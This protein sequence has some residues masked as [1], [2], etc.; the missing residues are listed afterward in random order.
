MWKDII[1]TSLNGLGAAARGE[2]C[3]LYG[4]NTITPHRVDQCVFVN[5]RFC[6]SIQSAG[7]FERLTGASH[8]GSFAHNDAK[9]DGDDTVATNF[10]GNGVVVC[11]GGSIG[12]F[13]AGG[14][15]FT[16]V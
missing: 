5:A 9:V 4:N 1:P 8:N 15:E 10:I 16:T 6:V 7:A 13:S 3:Q 2:N 12:I 14:L 11:P